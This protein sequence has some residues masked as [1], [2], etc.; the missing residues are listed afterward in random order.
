M[1][2]VRL[3]YYP[4]EVRALL[5]EPRVV[6]GMLAELRPVVDRARANAPKR[7]GMGAQSIRAEAVL[8]SWEVWF[9]ASWDR[10]HYYMHMHE[11]GTVRLPARPF[12][13][14]ALEGASR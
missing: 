4:W 11:R 7:T 6:Q 5:R 9:R 3:V 8:D 10:D 2:D 12:L 14:P 13:V 1:S